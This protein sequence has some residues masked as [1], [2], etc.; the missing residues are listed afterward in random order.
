LN[1]LGL[2]RKQEAMRSTEPHWS[3]ERAQALLSQGYWFGAL[4]KIVQQSIIDRSEIRRF[5]KNCTIYH[6][7]DLADGMYAV[8]EGDLRAYAY[9]DDRKRILLRLMAP[10]SWFGNFHLMDDCPTRGF[11]VRALSKC[12]A[13][14][15]SRK[16]FHELV[17]ASLENYRSFVKL[18]CIQQ[19]FL[20]RLEL[21]AHS[22]IPRRAVRALIRVA[23][24]HGCKVEGGVQVTVNITQSDL[25]SLIGVSRHDINELISIWNDGGFVIWKGKSAPVVFVDKLKT[26]LSPMDQRM[27]K[28]EGWV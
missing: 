22:N 18:V 28:A 25:A 10:T 15:L 9:S 24:T 21:E 20:L 14:F 1:E 3:K 26:L 12:A 27:L 8:L 5:K 7:G 11:E 19:R 2:A 16:N 6:I 23:K 17:D 4:P 13:L